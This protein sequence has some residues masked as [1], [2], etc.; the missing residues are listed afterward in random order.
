M[1]AI[2]H[3]EVTPLYPL[4]DIYL[5]DHPIK[6]AFIQIGHEKLKTK[7]AM[8]ALKITL[9]IIGMLGI[10]VG[11]AF[12]ISHWPYG[13]NIFLVCYVIILISFFIKTPQK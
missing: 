4:Y 8:K 2:Q 5:P 3:T 12:M 1:A 11:F 13:R 9:R 6:F 7:K 10:L